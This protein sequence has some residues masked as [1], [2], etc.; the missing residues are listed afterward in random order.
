MAYRT[1]TTDALV[2]GNREYLSSDK[3]FFLFTRDLGLVYGRAVSVRK[4]ASKLRY[5]LQDFS[6]V[7]CSLVRGKNGWRIVGAERSA[8][9]YYAAEERAARGALLRTVRLV[10]RFVRGEEAHPELYDTLADGLA[11]LS[12]STEG[13]SERLERILA[14]RLLAILGYIAPRPAYRDLLAAETLG[15]AG[16]FPSEERVV[17]RAIEEALAVSH[18]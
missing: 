7:R 4:E 1:Y 13:E 9:V 17:S 11:S 12:V 5:G 6:F 8:N 18:L 3:T 10:R 16:T 15:A 2:I 14:L